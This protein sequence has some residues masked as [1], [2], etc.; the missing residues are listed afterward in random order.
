MNDK[1]FLEMN[2]EELYEF[3]LEQDRKENLF[4]LTSGA[5][6]GSAVMNYDEEEYYYEEDAD[7]I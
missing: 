7:I 5:L 1:L 2:D 6:Y 4:K 3:Y